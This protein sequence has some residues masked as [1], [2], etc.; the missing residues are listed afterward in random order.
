MSGD[1][2]PADWGGGDGWGGGVDFEPC[3]VCGGGGREVFADG[4]GTAFELDGEEVD[5]V[6]AGAAEG[7]EGELGGFCGEVMDA[8][9][10]DGFTGFE[11]VDDDGFFFGG[12]VWA[13]PFDGGGDGAGGGWE[14]GD[15]EDDA[16]G[17]ETA[18]P[19]LRGGEPLFRRGGM[20][21]GGG[22]E[23]EQRQQT[24]GQRTGWEG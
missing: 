4:E 24:H 15:L 10:G 21:R 8:D 9:V 7:F 12:W 22:E 1:G 2:F 20:E 16:V 23:E 11:V 5:G 6:F 13:T 14:I 17:A 18:V 3:G 19:W